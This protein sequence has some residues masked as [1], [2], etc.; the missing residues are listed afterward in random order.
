MFVSF[1][2]LVSKKSPLTLVFPVIE[3]HNMY[4][5]S[6]FISLFCSMTSLLSTIVN[7]LLTWLDFYLALKIFPHS[8][9]Y[10][11]CIVLFCLPSLVSGETQEKLC[12]CHNLQHNTNETQ[13][14]DIVSKLVLSYPS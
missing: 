3:I 2:E 7:F 14:G 9:A 12:N 6:C 13:W 1:Q 4:Y 5:L 11:K 10:L 8:C